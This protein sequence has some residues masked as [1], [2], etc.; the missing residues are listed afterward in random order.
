MIWD[1]VNLYH[2]YLFRFILQAKSFVFFY[3]W[4]SSWFKVKCWFNTFSKWCSHTPMWIPILLEHQDCLVNPFHRCASLQVD[5]IIPISA[6]SITSSSQWCCLHPS[7]S[8]LCFSRP[9]TLF[10]QGFRFLNHVSFYL[11][12]FSSAFSFNV[13]PGVS[14]E[15]AK[16][17]SSLSLFTRFLLRWI[18]FKLSWSYPFLISNVSHASALLNHSPLAIHLFRSVEDILEESCFHS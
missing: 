7:S 15:D 13:L 3:L 16:G 18:Q 8:C 10:L 9:P 11:W 14:Y 4:Y 6:R 17:A 5:P 1:W 12:E 2:M